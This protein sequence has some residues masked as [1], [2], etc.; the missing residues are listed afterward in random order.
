MLPALIVWAVCGS[1]AAI[2][3]AR[4]GSNVW[5]WLALGLLGGP[6]GLI[7]S[8]AAGNDR[9]CEYCANHI[10]RA[11]TTCPRCNKDVSQ[12]AL[13]PPVF[14]CASCGYRAEKRPAFCPSC[15]EPFHQA[16]DMLDPLLERKKLRRMYSWIGAW[17]LLLGAMGAYAFLAD[18]TQGHAGRMVYADEVMMDSARTPV[19]GFIQP[20]RR[21][22]RIAKDDRVV[23]MPEVPTNSPTRSWIRI[24]SGTHSGRT[25]VVEW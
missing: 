24:A 10:D 23:R 25:G 20:G 13:K 19:N 6:F 11:A 4:L 15:R 16:E 5:L 1:V 9:K 8:F 3:A 18:P 14:E 12:S 22:F 2:V 17:I 7:F 21:P